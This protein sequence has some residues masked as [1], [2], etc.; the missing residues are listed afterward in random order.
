MTSDNTEAL[1][2]TQ[3]DRNKVAREV[4]GD[5]DNPLRVAEANRIYAGDRDHTDAVQEAARLR[6][7]YTPPTDAGEMPTF[8]EAWA[9][10]KA[11]GY[12]Y[13][14]DAL[15]NV[16]FGYRIALEE[17]SALRHTPTPV[18]NEREACAKVAD[19]Y[20]RWSGSARIDCQFTREGIAA[21]IRS[22]PSP[23]PECLSCHG[24]NTSCPDGCGRDPATGELDGS[25]FVAP[26][27]GEVERGKACKNC[28]FLPETGGPE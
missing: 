14:G 19:E 9:R 6:T 17:L 15:E 5:S 23:A 25:T 4:E 26:V 11:K 20:S 22:R 21:A 3:A 28:G 1:E 27:A 8:A 16:D 12:Q 7:R 10:Y 18:E 24:L 13:G 2:V